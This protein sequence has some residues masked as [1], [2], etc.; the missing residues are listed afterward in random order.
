MKK[1]SVEFDKETGGGNWAI[2]LEEQMEVKNG[3]VVNDLPIDFALMLYK[4]LAPALS[5]H[6][7]QS[8]QSPRFSNM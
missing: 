5:A 8:S 4:G 1:G 3:Q 6:P 7:P 2:N